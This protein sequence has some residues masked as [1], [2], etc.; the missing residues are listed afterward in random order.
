MSEEL[1]VRHGAPTLAGLK[2]A[3]LFTCPCDN[4]QDI[5]SFVRQQNSRL[6]RKG[7]RMIPLRFSDHKALLYLYRPHRLS[8][9]LSN[10]E[11][12]ALLAARGYDLSSCDRCVVQL[13]R[14]LRQS[15]DFPH[16]I[17]L[18]L[19]Y[20]AE[21]VRGFIENRA[22]GCKCVGCWKVYGDEAAA[23]KTFAQYKKCTRIYCE[24]FAKNN[25]IER[26][27]VAG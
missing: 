27:T 14:R 22:Q 12:E 19:G 26:L 8:A 24:Q 23:Q 17:G 7:V 3:N 4:K 5:L 10:G 9:D 6:Q 21:D 2:T 25:D 11:A 1:L 20:P 13:V 18:F 16:E 15:Q